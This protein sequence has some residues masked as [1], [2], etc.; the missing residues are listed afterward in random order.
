MKL[1]AHR[2]SIA[3]ILGAAFVGSLYI[4]FRGMGPAGWWGD[5]TLCLYDNRWAVIL[6]AVVLFGLALVHLT[7]G[8]RTSR[9]DQIL[10]FPNDSG[11]VSISTRGIADFLS[12]LQAEF[13]SVV[14][15][16]PRIIPNKNVIDVV[17]DVRVKA[18]PD[19]RDVCE[20]MQE[21]VR[22]N[23]AEGLGITDVGSVTVNVTEIVSER[24]SG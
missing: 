8:V 22:K 3:L 21:Q 13:A 15:M 4:I 6:A 16:R 17:V 23:M 12:K 18:G 20:L 14:S 5:L 7:T 10:S 1:L 19:I 9:G 24:K 2:I 11:A